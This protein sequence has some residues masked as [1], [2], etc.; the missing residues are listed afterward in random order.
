MVAVCL[1]V[2]A[3]GLDFLAEHLQTVV[4]RVVYLARL[5]VGAKVAVAGRQLVD[6]AVQPDVPFRRRLAA[7]LDGRLEVHEAKLEDVDEVV[8]LEVAEV[9]VAHQLGEIA[10]AD[11]IDALDEQLVKAVRLRGDEQLHAAARLR[12]QVLLALSLH[13]EDLVLLGERQQL[14]DVR[15][16][17]RN[18][19]QIIRLGRIKTVKSGKIF[20][21][22]LL[23][24]LPIP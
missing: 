4:A 15:V 18:V 13:R 24:R 8:R 11:I 12:Q 20:V 9:R 10:R 23:N 5:A 21:H 19:L 17:N 6:D 16:W 14:E 1:D 2:L 3:L 7:L 22:R